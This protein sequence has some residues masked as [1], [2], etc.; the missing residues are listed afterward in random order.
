MYVPYA[1]VLMGMVWGRGGRKGDMGRQPAW[2][3]R[4]MT[5]VRLSACGRGGRK[6]KRRLPPLPPPLDLQPH[7]LRDV[8]VKDA[9]SSTIGE[10]FYFQ[11]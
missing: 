3:S 4:K 8:N 9:D 10:M 7:L 11:D 2:D 1:T 6:G 5:M